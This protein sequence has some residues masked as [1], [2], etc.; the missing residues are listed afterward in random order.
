MNKNKKIFLSLGAAISIA[1]PIISTVSC[2]FNFGEN[3]RRT[4]GEVVLVTDTGSVADNSFNQSSWEG[5]QSFGA[6]FN[7]TYSYIIPSTLSRQVFQKSYSEALDNGANTLVLSG[8]HHE[9]YGEGGVGSSPGIQDDRL[10]P[11]IDEGRDPIKGF[12]QKYPNKHFIGIEVNDSLPNNNVYSLNFKASESSF[13]SAVYAGIYMNENHMIEGTTLKFAAYGGL[14]IGPVTGMLDGFLQ[15]AKYFND[16]FSATNP[17]WKPMEPIFIE[18]NAPTTKDFSGGF[19]PGLATEISANYLKQGAQIIVSVA[20]PQT[21]DTIGAIQEAGKVGKAFVIGPDTDQSLVYDKDIVFGTMAKGIQFA[22]VSTLKDIYDG[23]PATTPRDHNYVLHDQGI[24]TTDPKKMY[25][26]FL[27]SRS[28]RDTQM[29]KDVYATSIWTEALKLV[30][31]ERTDNLAEVTT[32]YESSNNK[33][34]GVITHSIDLIASKFTNGV[35]QAKISKWSDSIP[36][37]GLQNNSYLVVE[38]MRHDDE[39]RTAEKKVNDE[40]AKIVSEIDLG[41]AAG[42]QLAGGKTP[43]EAKAAARLAVNEKYNKK[44]PGILFWD[45]ATHNWVNSLPGRQF[46]GGFYGSW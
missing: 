22:A 9:F 2:G 19:A 7:K 34:A 36:I 10:T 16:I 39:I 26:G 30:D 45:S 5:I 15:G 31:K 29:D 14:P 3:Y 1:S 32:I 41:V 38:D 37:I 23:N 25:V 43:D 24:T 28:F 40:Y 27:P 46:A 13:L 20:G 17:G 11:F 12:E 35:K 42:R 8:F 44:A 33:N 4:G 6:H 18:G 21:A